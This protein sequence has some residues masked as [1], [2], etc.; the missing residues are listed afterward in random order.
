MMRIP[1]AMASLFLG[2]VCA[3]G[4]GA[5]ASNRVASSP[6]AEARARSVLRDTVAL[7]VE[8]ERMRAELEAVQNL[9]LV[10]MDE[11]PVPDF[12]VQTMNGTEFHSSLLVGQEPFVV[13]F[14]ATWCDVC[15]T[16]LGSLRRALAKSGS[17]LVIPVS[18]DGIETHDR[19]EPYLRAA[20][21]GEE[22]VFASDYPLFMF[23]YDPF[24]TVPLLVI[25]GRNGGL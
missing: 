20:G 14:F 23:S 10:G 19:V 21:L 12:D 7:E 5:P 17:M 13:A 16:K 2:A 3:C 25:V 22:A 8:A 18:V 11:G 15:E 6:A 9:R 4:G 1:R 24:N